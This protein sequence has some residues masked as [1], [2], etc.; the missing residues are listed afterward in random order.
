MGYDVGKSEHTGAKNGGGHWGL[1]VEAK[2]GSKKLRRVNDRVA[3]EED[4]DGKELLLTVQRGGAQV[5]RASEVI[6]GC[7]G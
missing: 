1:R 6:R 7:D 4:D 2:A 5:C 3:V